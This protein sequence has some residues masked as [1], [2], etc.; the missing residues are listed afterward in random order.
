DTGTAL[1]D[2]GE[3]TFAYFHTIICDEEETEDV[4]IRQ[5]DADAE[6]TVVE[7]SAKCVI[8]VAASDEHVYYISKPT[9]V[10]TLHRVPREGG[11]AELMPLDV[12]GWATLHYSA[13]QLIGSSGLFGYSRGR[14]EDSSASSF[15]TNFGGSGAHGQTVFPTSMTEA[16]AC[17]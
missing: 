7:A 3:V 13:G 5:I 6:V 16:G 9:G 17:V 14:P 8:A 12:D 4:G 2:A 15:A 1:A 10:S 11:Q